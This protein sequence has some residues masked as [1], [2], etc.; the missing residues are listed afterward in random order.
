MEYRARVTNGKC[1]WQCKIRMR[2]KNIN[3]YM[4][5]REHSYNTVNDNRNI[6]HNYIV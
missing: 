1:M 2:E 4:L 5:M 3:I 6:E